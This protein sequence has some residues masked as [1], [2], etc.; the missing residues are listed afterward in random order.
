LTS[1]QSLER[2]KREANEREA[3]ELKARDAVDRRNAAVQRR[4]QV[5]LIDQRVAD[6]FGPLKE[7]I[8]EF[9]TEWTPTE[10]EPLRAENVA[11]RHHIDALQSR[12]EAR[13]E[14]T[15]L[16]QRVAEPEAHKVVDPLE[17]VIAALWRGP[18][19]SSRNK[20]GSRR[21]CARTRRCAT[22]SPNSN[23]ASRR[24]PAN[25]RWHARSWRD[26]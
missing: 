1:S 15:A 22:A 6:H 17:D 26:G 24:S 18:T 3:R 20:R 8:G 7:A 25:W 13:D 5:A 2:C 14:N 9:I 21:S 16:Q 4:N 10:I 19:S 12:V 23:G 11:L